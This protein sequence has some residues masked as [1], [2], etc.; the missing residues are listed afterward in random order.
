MQNAVLKLMHEI[1][2]L[3]IMLFMVNGSRLTYD[4]AE[5]NS[6]TF[7]FSISPIAIQNTIVILSQVSHCTHTVT[8]R[9]IHEN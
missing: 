8:S 2:N 4:V 7:R 1:G 9:R 5:R 3:C 6:R